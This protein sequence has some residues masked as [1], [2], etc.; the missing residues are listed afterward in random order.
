VDLAGE[1]GLSGF[2]RLISFVI[3][4]VAC[5]YL[6]IPACRH[7]CRGV[8]SDI[9]HRQFGQGRLSAPKP[10]SEINR[11]CWF[12]VSASESHGSKLELSID[13]VTSFVTVT[14][15]LDHIVANIPVLR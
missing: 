9:N 15:D 7:R 13:S 11:R 5:G 2:H 14:A 3:S 6:D 10:D 12:A 1:A 4:G 8:W